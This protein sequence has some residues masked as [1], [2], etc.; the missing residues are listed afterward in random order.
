MNSSKQLVRGALLVA[1]A[2]VLQGIRVVLPLP[3][4]ASTLLIGTLVHMMLAVTLW[5]SG[6]APAI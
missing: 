3:P 1:L 2:L 5:Q 6:I 4:M